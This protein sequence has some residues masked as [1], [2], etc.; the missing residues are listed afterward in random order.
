MSIFIFLTILFESVSVSKQ[1]YIVVE[2]Q[3]SKHWLE[4]NPLNNLLIF[5][6]KFWIN[7][8]IFPLLNSHV[9]SSV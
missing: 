8:F 7:I 9:N 3:V 4:S 5:I 1:H 2:M 6:E